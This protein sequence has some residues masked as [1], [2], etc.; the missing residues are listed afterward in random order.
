MK[1][2]SVRIQN[3]RS[4]EDETIEFDDYTCLVGPNGG[5]KSTVLYALNIFFRETENSTTDVVNLSAQDFHKKITSKPITITVTFT[6]LSSDAQEDFKDYYRHGKLIVGVL[7]EYDQEKGA[8]LVQ[9]RGRRLG[10]LKF[11]PFFKAAKGARVEELVPIYDKIREQ[12]PD[13]PAIKTG[14]GMHK[15]LREYEDAHP[16]ECGPIWS[17]DEF[18]GVSNGVDRLIKY[19]QWIFVPATKNIVA[20][21]EENKSTALGKLLARTVRTSVKFDDE[22]REL[23][24]RVE[25][26]YREILKN[27]DSALKDLGN[28]LAKKLSKWAH[29]ATTLRLLWQKEAEKAVNITSPTAHAITGEG[30]FEGDLVRLGHGFQRSYL[31]T[32]LEVLASSR[33]EEPLPTLLLACEEPE[34]YQHPPQARHMSFLL[35]ELSRKGAQIFVSTHSPAFVTGKGFEGIRMVRF[36]QS[37]MSSCCQ[38]LTFDGIA[39]R[40]VA[41]GGRL[42]RPAGVAAKLHQILQPEMNDIFFSKNLVLVEGLEDVAYIKSW[43]LLSNR[44]D[45]YRRKGVNIVSVS[46]KHNLIRTIAIS[47]GLGIPTVTI[48]DAD[49]DQTDPDQ[50]LQHENENK[51][52]LGLLGGDVS[53]PF[54]ENVVWGDKYIVWPD[55]ITSVIKR[56]IPEDKFTAYKRTAAIEHGS[57][58]YLEKNTLFIGSILRLAHDDGLV[59]ATIDKACSEI[60]AAAEA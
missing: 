46:G 24:G 42:E 58:R 38:K 1:I 55:K 27:H 53:I 16:D 7:A 8:A 50:R 4:F 49:G 56:D 17:S 45:E 59:P 33:E 11:A 23:R 51:I 43:M 2:E 60:L 34:L 40:I 21:Q 22:I 48:F 39:S 47:Q 30:A 52:L 44:L 9:Y 35:E 31:L 12:V 20:E 57:V 19:I 15:A 37:K 18:Y 36:D 32:L 5:G 41:S 13:L 54:P 10:M 3:F 26:E 28:S 14:T 6:D 25:L 29:P